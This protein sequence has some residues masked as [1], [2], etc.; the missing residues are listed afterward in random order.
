M[1]L[2]DTIKQ[3]L[4]PIRGTKPEADP[5]VLLKLYIPGTKDAWYCTNGED[6][7][8]LNHAGLVPTGEYQL[9]GY[10]VDNSGEGL[11][12]FVLSDLLQLQSKTGERVRNDHY[13]VPVPLSKII[14]GAVR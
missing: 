11:D 8:L 6:Q 12:Y 13:W 9:Y 4:P 7:M 3:V 1:L 10:V 14:S 2:S 5:L